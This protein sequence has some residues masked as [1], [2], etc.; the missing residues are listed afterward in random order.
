MKKTLQALAF[1]VLLF[2]CLSARIF[3]P[4]AAVTTGAPI[5]AYPAP[6]TALVIIDIQKDMTEKDGRRLL[7]LA[8]TDAMI[9]VVN[10]LIQNAEKKHWLV[11][12][13]T[14]EFLKKS[15]LRLV[16][17]DF[18]LEGASGA[19]MDPRVLVASSNHFIKNRSDAFSNAEFDAFL[20]K[21]Q[22]NHLILTGMAAEACVDK[23]CRGGLNRKY[24]V[25]VVSDAIA[26]DSD[27][28]R[29]KKIEDYK[30]YG[31]QTLTA[32]ELL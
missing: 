2:L 30:S 8:Q 14:H 17:R 21:N 22:V 31:A 29:K 6:Q 25:T 10:T 26:G 12:Y 16:T 15:M 3:I 27:K 9:P 19:G 24:T 13:I 11:V 23:T 1:L 18:L 32:Q 28:S 5:A 7:N 4:F 20:R